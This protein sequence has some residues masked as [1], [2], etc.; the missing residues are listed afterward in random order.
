VYTTLT[1]LLEAWEEQFKQS[2]LL[3][4]IGNQYGVYGTRLA[5][6][7]KVTVRIYLRRSLA[8]DK[9]ASLAPEEI[10]RVKK[11]LESIIADADQ[12][13]NTLLQPHFTDAELRHTSLL[14]LMAAGWNQ[15]FVDGHMPEMTFMTAAHLLEAYTVTVQSFLEFVNAH[16]S[17]NTTV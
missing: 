9:D 3:Q 12:V 8:N 13:R 1:Q 16:T 14:M 17:V 15:D 5:S 6:M 10:A 2:S 4:E 7:S 11:T